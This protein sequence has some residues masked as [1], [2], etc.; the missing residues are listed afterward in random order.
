MMC[1][2]LDFGWV[3][4]SGPFLRKTKRHGWYMTPKKWKCTGVISY[5]LKERERERHTERRTNRWHIESYTFIFSM[6]QK[7]QVQQNFKNQS[8]SCYSTVSCVVHT[9]F[10]QFSSCI[11]H[12]PSFFTPKLKKTLNISCTYF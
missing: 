10:T 3:K 1:K 11:S 7:V 4:I 6:A 9:T 12:A 2:R 8:F 5:T